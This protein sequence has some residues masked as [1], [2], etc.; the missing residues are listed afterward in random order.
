MMKTAN[1]NRILVALDASAV[2]LSI[3]QAATTLAVN[4]DAQLNALFIEDINLFR[5]AEL[6]FAREIVYG[7]ET[8]RGMNVAN[9][10]RSVHMQTN[11]L[12]KLVETIAQQNRLSIAFDVKRGD[13]A[14]AICNASKQTDLLIF[15]KNTQLFK[16]SMKVGAIA[17]TLLSATHCNLMVLQHDAIIERP[18]VVTFDDSEASQDALSLATRLA[19]QD[20][21]ALIVLFP[22]VNDHRYQ[23]LY[24]QLMEKLN[25]T[26]LQI[27]PVRLTGNTVA[28]VLQVI[29]QYHGRILLMETGRSF[30]TDDQT[31]EIVMQAD[32][33]IILLR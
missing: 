14:S 30:L 9:M 13:I 5:L 10:E 23:Q 12:R 16:Q 17:R 18:V 25:D 15:G 4:L 31:Q 1:I 24:K 32:I 6:P 29:K 21:N 27:Y 2:N 20:H 28:Q 33:P 11:R 3:L 7:S 19:R 26:V 22:A 8:G